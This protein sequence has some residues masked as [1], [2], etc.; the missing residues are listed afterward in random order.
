MKTLLTKEMKLFASSLSY[1]FIAFAFMT[2]IPRYPILLGSFFVCLGI[3]QSFRDCGETNDILYTALLPIRKSDAVRSKYI[4]TC[5]IELVSFVFMAILTVLRMT[6]MSDAIA[7]SGNPLMSANPVFLGFSLLIFAAFNLIFLKGFFKTGGRV[8]KPFFVFIGVAMLIVC[9]GEILHHLP[10]LEFTN[11]IGPAPLA[12]NL[13]IFAVCAV[14]FA[15]ITLL[16]QK[17]AIAAF[18][19]IDL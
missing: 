11:S 14:L 4:F 10:G 7:Y 3:F 6:V 15:A 5:F 16:S 2:L 18:E 12:A 19:K 9:A 13:V 8:G 1:I 17:G